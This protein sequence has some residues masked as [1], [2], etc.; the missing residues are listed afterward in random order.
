[1]DDNPM[2]P[3]PL[4][5]VHLSLAQAVPRCGAKTR[6]GTSCQAPVI[7]GRRKCRLHGGL[8]GAPRGERH[9]MFCHG[10]R[11]IEATEARRALRVLMRQLIEELGAA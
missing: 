2:N 1:M 9:G 7:H 5:R 6:R 11:T 10:M 4:W 8:G 3:V